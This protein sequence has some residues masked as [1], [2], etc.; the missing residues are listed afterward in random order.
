MFLQQN[1]TNCTLTIVYN[2]NHT[3]NICSIVIPEDSAAMNLRNSTHELTY[4]IASDWFPNLS[5]SIYGYGKR[6]TIFK[7][8]VMIIFTDLLHC[9]KIVNNILQLQSCVKAERITL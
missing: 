9:Y 4:R 8:P 2:N 7:I 3:N 6:Q 1:M 5:Y